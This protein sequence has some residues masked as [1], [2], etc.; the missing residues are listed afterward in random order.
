MSIS[1]AAVVRLFDYQLLKKRHSHTHTHTERHILILVYKERERNKQT[2]F[3]SGSCA[4]YFLFLTT[5]RSQ[6]AS[7]QRGRW[8][9]RGRAGDRGTHPVSL[10]FDSHIVYKWL[11]IFLWFCREFCQGKFSEPPA[12]LS[13]L[14]S[15]RRR[16]R[17][18]HA[19]RLIGRQLI[20]VLNSQFSVSILSSPRC[21]LSAPNFSLA[22]T[23]H[24]VKISE[25]ANFWRWPNGN[26]DKLCQLCRDLY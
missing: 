3:E 9:G 23:T 7:W 8:G 5:L 19:T 12:Q 4:A 13:L 6:L 15:R 20:P 16:C 22:K 21:Q 24:G 10:R 25:Y 26:C 2:Q 17:C 18:R 11:P 1:F 14:F